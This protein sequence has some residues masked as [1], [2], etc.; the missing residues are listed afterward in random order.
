MNYVGTHKIKKTTWS[1][2][3]NDQGFL[4]LYHSSGDAKEIVDHGTRI[5][6]ASDIK[7]IVTNV[8]DMQDLSD[9]FKNKKPMPAKYDPY[10]DPAQL[11]I[12]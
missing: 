5:I 4:E 2:F 10:K 11:S 9:Y 8:I 7:R 12:A 1:V 3:R 6:Y